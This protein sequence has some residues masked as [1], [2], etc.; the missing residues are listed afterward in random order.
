MMQKEPS[1]PWYEGVTRSQWTV[2]AIASLGWLF[3]V[4]EGQLYSVLK[5]P[6]VRGVL[7]PEASPAQVNTI[8]GLTLT[9][10]LAGGAVGGAVF[11]VLGDRWGRRRV[12]V[13]TI[14]IY[15]FF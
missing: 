11:G 13:L 3:D 7:G 9:A 12:M 1:A 4:F 8:A 15:S 5:T 14:L 6:A 2:L 10:F